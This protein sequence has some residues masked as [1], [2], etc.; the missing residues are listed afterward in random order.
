MNRSVE[1]LRLS[2]TGVAPGQLV[3][4]AFHH[5][6]RGPVRASAAPLVVASLT[7]R[8]RDVLWGPEPRVVEASV[9]EAVQ[10]T[11]SYLERG[12]D[13]VGFGIA[14]RTDDP[15]GLLLA[16]WAVTDWAAALRTRR[17]LLAGAE[18]LCSGARQAGLLIAQA[19]ER[20]REPVHVLGA[21]GDCA[22]ATGPAEPEDVLTGSELSTVPEGAVVAYPAHGVAPE[23]HTEALLRGLR[24]VDATCPLVAAAHE[25][26]RLVAG[27]GDTV[28]V[29]GDPA[30]RGVA[31]LA[32]QAGPRA[33]VVSRPE[34][35]ERL[36]EDPGR[37]SFV[38]HPGMEIP[39][40]ERVVR[41]LRARLRHVRGAHPDG[42]C[43]ARTDRAAVVRVV[44]ASSQACLVLGTPGTAEV[45]DLV[46]LAHEAGT[47][48]GVVRTLADLPYELIAA[49]PAVGVLT[50]GSAAPGLLEE[51]LDALSGL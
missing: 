10:F 8:G 44:A 21:L 15:G 51:V 24:V 2:V 35:L 47:P 45:A 41:A 40:A 28:V 43:Y 34:E 17:V 6:A 30:H 20:Q 37:V 23:V 25:E 46:R 3:V 18:P 14:A 9:A 12:G 38:V 39:R 5:P 22:T 7:G 33:V 31:A 1:R 13:A 19:A 16:E 4:S 48:V 49:A 26:A 27:E 11:V 42:Y 29:I 50:A 32:E 36:G